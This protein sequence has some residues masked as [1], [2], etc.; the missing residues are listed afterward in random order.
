MRS[1]QSAWCISN[2][3]HGTD[4]LCTLRSH[5]L[6]PERGLPPV[7]Q[8]EMQRRPAVADKIDQ[9]KAEPLQKQRGTFR[10]L[11]IE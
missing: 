1:E 10:L 6:E 4:L 11:S 3:S 5:A 2:N 8:G 9:D 7:Q